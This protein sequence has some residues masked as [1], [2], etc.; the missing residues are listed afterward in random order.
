LFLYPFLQ[1]IIIRL[2]HFLFPTVA[3][4]KETSTSRRTSSSGFSFYI[5]LTFY[6]FSAAFCSIFIKFAFNFINVE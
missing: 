2:H 4:S 3:N 5:T 1:N 6:G